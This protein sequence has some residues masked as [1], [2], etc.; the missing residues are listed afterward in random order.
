[1]TIYVRKQD[2]TR[3]QVFVVMLSYLLIQ[4]L[5]EYWNTLDMTV[6]EGIELLKTLCTVE[7]QLDGN[8]PALYV[9]KPRKEIEQLLTLANIPIPE[10]LPAKIKSKHQNKTKKCSQQIKNKN[11]T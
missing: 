11:F 8:I 6:E 2:R 9:P 5:R 4:K 1:M 7:I 3:G 10:I